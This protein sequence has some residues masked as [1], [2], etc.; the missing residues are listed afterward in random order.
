MASGMRIA[1]YWVW[2]CVML[3]VGGLGGVRVK[4]RARVRV[5]FSAHVRNSVVV[6]LCALPVQLLK[7]E[8]AQLRYPFVN[9]GELVE[10]LSQS[11]SLKQS[12]IPQR[13]PTVSP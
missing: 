7:T 4:A 2:V 10:N 13:H 12:P 1:D 3:T 5:R 6:R 11:A 8:D 9:L